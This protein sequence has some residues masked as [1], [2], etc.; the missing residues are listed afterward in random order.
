M[1][2]GVVRNPPP[3]PN[4]PDKIPVTDWRKRSPIFSGNPRSAVAA[5]ARILGFGDDGYAAIEAVVPERLMVDGL[6][7][8]WQ[9]SDVV[10]SGL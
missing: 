10:R 4:S 9:A 2:S 1:S 6:L 5:I 8:V 7:S 3:T